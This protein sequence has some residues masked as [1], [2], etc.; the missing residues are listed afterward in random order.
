M[1]RGWF[2]PALAAT[3]LAAGLWWHTP[4]VSQAQARLDVD[5]SGPRDGHVGE[6]LTWTASVKETPVTDLIFTWSFGDGTSATGAQVSHTYATPAAYLLSCTVSTASGAAPSNTETRTVLITASDTAAPALA[7]AIDLELDIPE[8]GKAGEPI[9]MSGSVAGVGGPEPA[10]IGWKWNFG[11]GTTGEDNDTV[12][13]TYAKRGVYTVSAA[14]QSVSH[15]E[16]SEDDNQLITIIDEETTFI[17]LHLIEEG[18]ATAI[19]EYEPGWNLVSGWTGQTFPQAVGPL[20]TLNDDG[21]DYVAVPNTQGIVAARAYWAYFDKH[22]QVPL[23]GR[24]YGTYPVIVFP[25]RYNMVGAESPAY[26]E[27]V[28]GAGAV[29][30][31]DPVSGAWSQATTLKWGQGA[32]IFPAAEAGEAPQ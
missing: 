2:L 4:A 20:Y 25:G 32:F 7:K 30:T 1:H 18:M 3:I 21:S 5:V 23:N 22:T 17:R 16:L 31:Y 11:D 27:R 28:S 12:T 19:A 6:S 8:W 29:Y 15:P 9:T 13:H 26:N 14:V 24:G 10:D